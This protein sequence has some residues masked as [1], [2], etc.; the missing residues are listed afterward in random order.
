M[1]HEVDEALRTLIADRA[2]AGANVEVAFEAPSR[3]WAAR[4]TAPTINS[5]LYDIRED[6]SRRER[7]PHFVRE[8]GEITGRRQPPRF[9]RLSY[10][11]TAWTKLPQDEHR[12]LAVVLSGLLRNEI[13]PAEALPSG[14]L[15]AS[16]GMQIPV[17]VA[18]PPPEARS[19]ADIWSAL[20]GDLKPSLDVVV[21]A[22]FPVSPEYPV[23][24]LAAQGLETRVGR[25]P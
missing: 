12:L 17:T 11:V 13:L 23:A 8:N 25:I 3:D 4:R 15:L 14:G 16:A 1:I 19:I 9:Y 24:P 20:G 5:Y 21:T 7:G 18:L 2:L 10:L 22:P 6:T